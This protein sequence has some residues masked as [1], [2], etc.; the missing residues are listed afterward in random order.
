MIDHLY[1]HTSLDAHTAM[2]SFYTAVLSPLGHT[3]MAEFLDGKVVGFGIPGAPHPDFWI[4]VA[5]PPNIV[6]HA[7]FAFT[8]KGE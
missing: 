8:A 5:K 2:V 4:G 1:I 7:H 3:K 6:T